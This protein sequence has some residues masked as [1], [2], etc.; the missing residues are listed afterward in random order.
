MIHMM[1]IV[2]LV[3]EGPGSTHGKVCAWCNR[4]LREGGKPVSHGICP[5]CAKREM[6]RY[7]G[8]E[9]PAPRQMTR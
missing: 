8:T 1:R 4:I 5:R 7:L 6:D 9:S 2:S 3:N